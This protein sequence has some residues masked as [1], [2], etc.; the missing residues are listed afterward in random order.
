MDEQQIRP[1]L[2]SV[3][4]RDRLRGRPVGELDH[5]LELR[6]IGDQPRRARDVFELRV[7]LIADLPKFKAVV[8]LA[9]RPTAEP[10]AAE[11]PGGRGGSAAPSWT[12][13][14]RDALVGET[15]LAP[16]RGDP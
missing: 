12:G 8:E 16:G 6:Q 14:G 7:A 4:G 2:H 13:A 3:V 5:R 1:G 10:I 15:V 11:L 9:D